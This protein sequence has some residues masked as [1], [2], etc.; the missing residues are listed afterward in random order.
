MPVCPPS[1]ACG[2]WSGTCGLRHSGPPDLSSSKVLWRFL[3]PNS[4][5]DP[6][7]P[8]NGGRGAA[9][10]PPKGPTCGC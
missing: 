8:V 1:P 6:G 7:C 4:G 9:G 5:E 3:A 2:P 10:T